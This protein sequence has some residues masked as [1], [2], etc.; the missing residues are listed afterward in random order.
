MKIMKF[1]KKTV[2][3]AAAA[4]VCVC[5]AGVGL[6]F[7]L[8]HGK[9]DGGKNVIYVNTVE[10][11][12]NPGSGNGSIN[13]FAGVVETQKKM[14]IQL[15]QD[16]T[17]KEI[18]VEEGQEVTKGTPLFVYDTEKSQ[19][20]LSKAQLELERIN[21]TIGNKTNEIA[22]LE[23]E[24]KSAG[25]DAQLDYTMQI[26]SAQM[27]LK[28]SEYEKKS[29]QVEIQ[30]LEDSIENS[31]VV[32]EMDGVV[33]SINNGNSETNMNG[34][35]TAFMTLIALGDYRVKGK[36]NEQNMSSVMSGQSVIVHSRIDEDVTW[37]G[38]MGE[39]DMQNP[40]NDSASYGF[41]SSDG[42]TQSNSY[43]FYVELDSSEGLM[44]GQ[45]VYIEAD[46][47][48]EEEKAGIWL[49]EYLICDADSSPYVWADNGKG[50]LEK[51]S[52]T[53]GQHDEELYQYE[54]AEGLTKEDMITFPEEGLEEGMSTA[55]GEGGQMG[56]E[57]PLG[58]SG[59]MDGTDMME[60]GEGQM[61]SENITGNEGESG[62]MTGA[63]GESG[64]MTGAEGESGDMTGNEGESGDMTGNEG[65]SGDM[66][67]NEGESGDMT[68]SAGGS[69]GMTSSAGGSG[70]MTV[71]EGEYGVVKKG[72]VGSVGTMEAGGAAGTEAVQ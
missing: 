44:L 67:G 9:S 4:A 24:K 38:T 37:K 21:N 60:N 34:E 15:S 27:E 64:D 65:E 25:S 1:K 39:V 7:F 16:K 28:Q 19:E 17:V 63:E 66:T 22:A 62:D 29:K 48:Q 61:E 72:N 57:Q 52:V 5:L 31:Q 30:K 47:G 33:K 43:P 8:N 23:K 6:W 54:I 46:Y 70:G 18:L 12:M 2:V 55:K 68:S 69:G 35:S 45:H 14:D 56:S 11:I 50:K 36:V 53:L 71:I 59:T 32:S 42:T 40:G 10:S 58:E 13:R 20:D 26:Q 3:I 41:S 51:R 49:D